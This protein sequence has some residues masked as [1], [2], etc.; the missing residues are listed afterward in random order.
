MDVEGAF[1]MRFYY[2]FF[3]QVRFAIDVPNADGTLTPERCRSFVARSVLFNKRV[4]LFDIF[5]LQ[6]END[7]IFCCLAS[8]LDKSNSNFY[9]EE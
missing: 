6:M 3:F 1:V 2:F 4:I 7:E 8:I 5:V 9:I